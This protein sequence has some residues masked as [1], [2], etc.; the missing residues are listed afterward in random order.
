MYIAQNSDF[1]STYDLVVIGSGFGSLFFLKKWLEKASKNAQVAVIEHGPFVDHKQQIAQQKNSPF[2]SQYGIKTLKHQKP[3]NY[4]LAVGGGTNCWFGQTPRMMPADFKLKSLY[5]VGSDWPIDYS[6]L[7]S[8]YC[9]AEE[10]MNISGPDISYKLFPR[11]R[12]YPL[13]PH[14]PSTPDRAML[15]AYPDYHMIIPTARASI[16]TQSRGQCC[17]TATC[18]LCPMDAKFTAQN[19]LND[20]LSDSRIKWFLNADV[21]QLDVAN[22]MIKAAVFKTGNDI[23]KI[24]GN[25]FVLGANAIFSP[26]ILSRSGLKHK[27]LGRGINEQVG[28]NMEVLL[29]GMKNFDGSTL[30]T[31]LNFSEYDGGH[32]KTSAA[33]LY[34]FEN[35]WNTTGMRADFKRWREMLLI[36]LN[37]EDLPSEQNYLDIPDDWNDL[38]TVHHTK[39]STYADRGID[40][41]INALPTLLSPLPVEDIRRLGFRPTE[42]HLLGTTVMGKDASHSICDENQIHH[43]SRNLVIVGS[44]VFP[45]CAPANPSLTVAALSLRA[46]DKL[47]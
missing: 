46:A 22:K 45:S 32:R 30:T 26:A 5:G 17:S 40:R 31:T 11:S 35:R 24:S 15:K 33:V 44:G 14:L 25:L 34:F 12:P 42:S 37:A 23:R 18:N 6:E 29:K 8:W 2:L 27:V 19:G 4:T 13:P 43:Q 20:V 9:E 28:Y 1:N 39:H 38:I 41:A 47:Q 10:I 21:K 3:W 16:P 7:E 36:S